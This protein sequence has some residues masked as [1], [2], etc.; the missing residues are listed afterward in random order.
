[1]SDNRE[2]VSYSITPKGTF[3]VLL[4]AMLEPYLS[5]LEVAD[6]VFN[7]RGS[8]ISALLGEFVEK[9]KSP[10][11]GR[12]QEINA[13]IKAWNLLRHDDKEEK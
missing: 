2:T 7:E 5:D 6:L 4:M 11:K 1:M 13:D 10:S 9:W 12:R 3:I 8:S